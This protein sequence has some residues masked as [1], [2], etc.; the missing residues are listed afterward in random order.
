[1]SNNS[2]GLPSPQSYEEILGALL[3]SYASKIG[4]N[5]FQVGSAVSSFFEVVALSTARASGDIFQILRDHNVDRAAGDSLKRLATENNVIPASAQPTTGTVT[6]TDT[7]M[8]KIS[9]KIYAGATPPNS[10]STTINVSDASLFPASGYIYLGRGTPNVEGPLQYSAKSQN[11]SFWTI[12]LVTGTQKFHNVGESVIF[13]QKGNR[14]IPVN[15]VVIAPA[16]GASPDIVFYVTVSSVILDGEASVSGVQVSAQTPGTASNVPIGAI[17][18]I[19]GLP[20]NGGSVTNTL[21]FTTGTDS[22]SDDTLRNRI[23]LAMSSKGLGTATAIQSAL[24]GV[25]APDEQDSITS[26]SILTTSTGTIVYIDNGNGYEAKTAGIGIESI[27]DSALGGEQYFQLTTGGTQAPVAKAFLVS[28]NYAPFDLIGTDTLSV[29]VGESTSQHIFSASDFRSPGGATAYEVIASI[30]ANTTLDFEATT[31]NGGQQIVIRSKLEGNDSIK[32]N[33][34]TTSG[35]NAALLLGFQSN[36]IQTLRLFKNKIPL[37]KDGSTASL[38]TQSQ[39]SWSPNIQDGDTLILS[40]DGTAEVTYNFT[41]SDFLNTGLYTTIAANNSL[42][43]WAQVFNNKIAGVTTS[44][45]GSQLVLASNLGASNRAKLSINSSSS[46]VSKGMFSSIGLSITGTT[47]DYILDR[48]TAQ[49]KLTTP[50]VA[51]DQLTAGSTNTQAQIKSSQITAG[52]IVLSSDAY[53]WLLSDSVGQLVNTGVVGNTLLD[54]SK[55]ST[56]II[57]YTSHSAN[58]FSNVL[59]GDYVIVWSTELPASDRLEGRVHALTSTSIDILVTASEYAAATSVADVTFND[60]FVILRSKNAPQKFKVTAGTKSL[61]VI[62][63][64]LQTQSTELTFSVQ[65]EQYFIISSNT[66]NLSGYIMSVTADLQGKSLSIPLG[67]SDT[68]KN[69]LLAYYDST[70]TQGDFPLF[71]HSTFATEASADPIDSY[72]SSVNSAISLSGRDPNELINILQPYGS[73][74]AQP[75]NEVLQVTTLSG[76]TIGLDKNSVLKRLRTSDRFFISNPLDFGSKDS[77]TA[78]VDG[79]TNS[80]SF[81]IPFYRRAIT[82]NTLSVNANNFNAYD[83][84]SGTSANFVDAFGTF[85]FSNFKAL[86]QARKVLKPTPSQTAILYRSTK[87]GRSGEKI[88]VGYIYPTA[89]GAS[90]VSNVISVNSEVDINIILKSGTSIAPNFDSST[91]WN[92]SI[93]PNNPSAG[94]DQVT[95]TYSGVGTTPALSLSGGEYVNISSFSEFNTANTGVFKISTQSGFLPTLTSFTV[96][97]KNGSAVAELNKATLVNNAITFYNKVDTSAADVVAYVNS[98]LSDYFSAT[99]MDDGGLTGSGIINL[100]T[101]EDSGFTYSNVQLKDGINWIAKSDFSISSTHQFEF[102]NALTLPTDVGYSFINSEEVRLVPTTMDQVSRLIS[103][104][105]VSGFTT[106]G[107][108]NNVNRS[109]KLELSTE[110]VGS[111]GSLQILGGLANQYS[112]SVIGS[113]NRVNNSLMN[114]ST[115]KISSAGVH[116]DQWFR[117]Q[118]SYAQQKEALFSSNTSITVTSNSPTT[119]QAT[120][121][122]FGKQLNQRYFGRPRHNTRIKGRTFKIEKQGTLTCLS[123]NGVGSGPMFNKPSLNFNDLSGGTLNVSTVANTNESLYTIL[124]GSV[125]FTELAINDL[126]TITGSANTANDGTF[127]VTGVSDNGTSLRV[128]NPNA[129]NQLS[130]GTFTLSANLTNGDQFTVNG[131]T[132]TAVTSSPTSNQFL[133]QG[134]SQLTATMLSSMIGSISG[135]TSTYSGNVVTVTATTVSANIAISYTGSP[136][137]AVSG[138]Y[139]AGDTIVPGMFTADSGVSEGDTITISNISGSPFNTLNQGTFRIIRRFNDSVWFENSNTIEEEVQTNAT[140]N[141]NISLGFAADT[142]FKIWPTNNSIYMNWNGTGTEPHLENA[143]MGD[144]LTFGTDFNIA[145]RGDFMVSRSGAKLQQIVSSNMP[146]GLQLPTTGVGAYFDIYSAAAV[147]PYRVW[148][149]ADPLH[150]GST[151]APS[152]VGVT[153]VPVL[154]NSGLTTDSASAIANL[155][156]TAIN[157]QTGLTSTAVDNVLT[158]TTTDSIETTTPSNGTM[159]APFAFTVLQLGRRTFVECINPAV[160][161]QSSV[162]VSTDILTCFRPQI[163]FFEYETTVAGDKLVVT[164]NTLSA[165]NAGTY[166]IVKVIDNSTVVV[167]GYMA[168]INNASMNNVESSVFVQEGIPYTGYKHVSFAVVQPGS[169]TRTLLTFDTNAQY[170]KIDESA[171][172]QMISLNKMN[173][174][175]TIK[176]GLDSYKYNTGLIALANKIIYGDPRDNTTYAGVGAAGTDI[177]V[178]EPL[179]K[180]VQVAINIRVAT[181]VPFAQTSEQIRSNVSYLINSN[182]IGQSIS[183]SSI[184]SVVNV[185]PGV[186]AVSISFPQYDISN[187][188]ILLTPG[189]KARIIDPVTDI[190]ISLV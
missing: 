182:D 27:V 38:Y 18:Y 2:N 183:I 82:N 125:N 161:P 162:T 60:G 4:V 177:F 136:V 47:V 186:K 159:P 168:S 114:I 72:V 124:T 106:V 81:E 94:I 84:D 105:A 55:P 171:N 139:L 54:V 169:S 26:S 19:S 133:I 86:M 64:E 163:Q 103:V 93:T 66:K 76:S 120:V 70:E 127:L 190:S 111:T 121:Q 92:V 65:N 129:V 167:S 176:N 63:S 137:V 173:F 61:N 71:I 78:I 89:A 181:G 156:K 189:N 77:L 175:T 14:S 165:N 6:I 25:S 83:V 24:Y 73:A 29:T 135:V 80:K 57:R 118:A 146:T 87:W 153:L 48:N 180:R 145:N 152:S 164:G 107:T 134:T 151:T 119:G 143:Q 96:Q 31:S 1:M 122:F 116:S 16:S 68:S 112:V 58:A 144:I 12:T 42:A 52:T 140:G 155:T 21:P 142:S 131:T 3:S 41:N 8:S 74:D 160:A 17:K 98:N 150:G 20:W 100:S 99:L 36:Q 126:V 59:L 149:N 147:V 43:S 170:E 101:F 79:D 184:V 7:S 188:M 130:H 75:H 110:T 28:D 56:N 88:K 53:L 62:A 172:V 40:V 90:S 123:W 9:S 178:R 33:T 23:K 148:F 128:L 32:V 13:A 104:L 15:S 34:P 154:F 187:D 69:S 97:R 113:A 49:F 108:I 132:I 95:Y 44:V 37:N 157:L 141:F 22:E 35:R 5:D 51:G 138:S 10:N 50:L 46:L 91:S 115:D 109:S 45:V 102:K 117:L 39:T 85:D 179:I 158:I 11:G 174:N 185:I 67:I 166:I 30:N